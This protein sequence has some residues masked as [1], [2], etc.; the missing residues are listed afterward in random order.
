L[1]QK[2]AVET[3][4]DVIIDSIDKQLADASYDISTSGTI[5][6]KNGNTYTVQAFGD[7]YSVTS[8]KVFNVGQAVIVTALQGNKKNLV[9]SEGNNDIQL[10]SGITM[11]TLSENF[12]GLSENLTSNEEIVQKQIDGSLTTWYYYGEPSETTYPTKDWTTDEAKVAHVE[13][14]YFDKDTKKC[15]R[16]LYDNGSYSWVEITNNSTVNAL[17]AAGEALDTADNKRRI[18][19]TTPTTPYDIGDLWVQGQ[20][21]ETS[22][23]EYNG[24]ILRCSKARTILESYYSTDWE[25]ASK[26][27]DDTKANEVEQ[28]V[29]ETDEKVEQY[30]SS[31]NQT[32]DNITIEVGKKVGTDNVRSAFAMSSE[33]V[34]ISS[35]TITFNTGALVVNGKNF[36]LDKNGNATFSG[37]V[38]ANKIVNSG[39]STIFDSD[40]Y[41]SGSYVSG[42]VISGSIVR[43]GSYGS[44]YVQLDSDGIY[45]YDSIS[46][47]VVDN[48]GNET[49][50]SG[51]YAGQGRTAAYCVDTPY[52]TGSL[53]L[54]FSCGILVD[55]YWSK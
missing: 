32:M 17:A 52:A 28:Q 21:D 10:S 55:H 2:D 29:A 39:G 1:A 9:L 53:W 15:Y 6:A 48:E 46:H 20:K 26:Y 14:I 13:D 12:Q 4:A 47:Y 42:G 43:G 54:Y 19:Y 37:T 40:G 51:G 33:N 41:L 5:I 8:E 16:W 11:N 49:T 34:T 31:I 7:Q 35:G 25:L 18:F 30:Y 3:I 44:R 23:A 22:T 24:D 36:S 45:A 50:S 27:T 38:Q